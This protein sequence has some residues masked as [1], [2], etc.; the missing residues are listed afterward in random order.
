MKQQVIT[1]IEAHKII[2][3]VRGVD[4]AA[5]V[6]VAQALYDGGIRLMEI[7]FNQ[8][9][10]STFAATAA[11]IS[12]LRTEYEGRMCIGAGTVLSVQQAEQAAAAGAQYIISPDADPEVIR[13]TC[14]LGLVSIP[15]AMT[16]SEIKAA[17]NAGADFVKLFPISELGPGYVRA[18]RAPLGHIRML[19]VGGVNEHNAADFLRAGACG[20]G[21]GGNL[22]NREWIAAGAFEKITQT[23][24]ALV[25]SIQNI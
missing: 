18:L 1:Q 15:G 25:E 9:D 8:K 7:T 20:L 19:A 2:A 5:C 23:A 13:R 3:I 24:Q 14:A 22:A 12:A 11:S 10:P 16:A 21:V 4:P 17:H 6:K